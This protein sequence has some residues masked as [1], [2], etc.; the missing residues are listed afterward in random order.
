MADTVSRM[1]GIRV[2][3]CAPDGLKLRTD[4]DAVDLVGDA[5]SQDAELVIVPVERLGDGFFTL[6]TRIAGEIIQKFVTY[7]RRLAILGDI[8]K[9]L[10]ESSA[11]RAFVYETNRG[12]QVWFV[13]DL[14]ELRRRLESTRPPASGD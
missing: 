11:L 12:R 1:H 13:A 10:A 9:Y 2:L 5:L 14:A 4:R 6:N 8:S 7:R 3:T